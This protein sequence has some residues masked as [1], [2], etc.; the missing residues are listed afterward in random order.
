MSLS[1][2]RRDLLKNIFVR[3]V[4]SNSDSMRLQTLQILSEIL[5]FSPQEKRSLGL[6]DASADD[7]ARGSTGGNP[8]SRVSTKFL[9]FQIP[10]WV[11]DDASTL[12]IPVIDKRVHSVH[13][14]RIRPERKE[15]GMYSI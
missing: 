12:Y 2:V 3:Y 7:E 8:S 13:G 4:T 10:G 11:F 9:A 14:E 1:L 6:S 15:K 5:N